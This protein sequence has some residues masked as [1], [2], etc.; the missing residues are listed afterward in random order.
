MLKDIFKKITLKEYLLI[1]WVLALII[2]FW[3]I[4]CRNVLEAKR[5]GA[6]EHHPPQMSDILMRNKKA[7]TTSITDVQYI[8]AW[9]TFKY[10]NFVFDLPENYLKDSL[11]IDEK[12]YP[13]IPIGKYAKNKKL[14]Q[15][16]VM[17]EVKKLVWNFMSANP[18][19]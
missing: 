16:E 12:S 10:V 4:L 14:N 9:M 7:N 1:A 13:N 19:K 11:T 17:T 6:F 15:A 18:K 2:V 5:S 3:I 8:N